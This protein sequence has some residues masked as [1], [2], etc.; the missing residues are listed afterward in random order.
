MSV[1]I[2][3]VLHLNSHVIMI[4]VDSNV[5]VTNCVFLLLTNHTCGNEQIM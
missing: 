2:Y 3:S 1:A 5:L 4:K